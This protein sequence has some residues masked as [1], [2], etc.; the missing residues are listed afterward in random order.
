MKIKLTH[1]RS[2]FIVGNFLDFWRRN[3]HQL[4]VSLC[5]MLKLS[6]EVAVVKLLSLIIKKLRV[7]NV[8]YK[9]T[10]DCDN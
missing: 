7:M 9:Q 4:P 2:G 10:A 8:K 3:T 1:I 6:E 5:C